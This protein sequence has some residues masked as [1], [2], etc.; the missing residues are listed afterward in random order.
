MNTVPD[1]LEG[2]ARE[3]A[4]VIIDC[5]LIQNS[6]AQ[7]SESVFLSP[8]FNHT[9]YGNNAVLVV[10]HEEGPHRP[11]FLYNNPRLIEMYEALTEE[12]ALVSLWCEQCTDW[13]SAIY[14]MDK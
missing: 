8:E 1:H 3:A 9:G 10:L 4:Q 12:L 13:C 14:T 2:K 5:V 11:F 6:Q 7:L